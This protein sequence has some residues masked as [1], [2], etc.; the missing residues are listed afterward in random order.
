MAAF[1]RLSATVTFMQKS[2]GTAPGDLLVSADVMARLK[3]SRRTLDRL[4]ASG[5]LPVRRIAGSGH[6]RYDPADVDRLV[7]DRAVA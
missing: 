7:A 6:R 2:H 4:V 1:G 3:I 5:A